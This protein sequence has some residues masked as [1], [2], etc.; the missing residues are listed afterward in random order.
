MLPGFLVFRAASEDVRA[1]SRDGSRSAR[2]HEAA[3]AAGESYRVWVNIVRQ[4]RSERRTNEPGQ[5]RSSGENI[6][7]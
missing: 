7:H 1:A 6:I 4:S 2:G 3:L 5:F